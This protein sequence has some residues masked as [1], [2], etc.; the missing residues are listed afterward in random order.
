V[1]FLELN[2]LQTCTIYSLPD[3]LSGVEAREG[4]EGIF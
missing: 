1:I 2:E 4:W 3:M